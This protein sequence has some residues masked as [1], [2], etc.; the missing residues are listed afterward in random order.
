M[1]SNN[2]TTFAAMSTKRKVFIALFLC[3]L[4]VVFP[5]AGYIHYL[6][7]KQS[8]AVN[9]DSLVYI[10]TS[11]MAERY[12]STPD[13]EGLQSCGGRIQAVSKDEAKKQDKTPCHLFY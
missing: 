6:T 12:H 8:A 2:L 10:C 4:M 3:L 9:K 5:L 1:V 13:C 11:N 7:H